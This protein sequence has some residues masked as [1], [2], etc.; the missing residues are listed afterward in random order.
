[1]DKYI[2]LVSQLPMLHFDRKPLISVEDFLVEADKWLSGRDHTV[3]IRADLLNVDP[4]PCDTQLLRRYKA[5]ERDFRND[6][7]R[8]RQTKGSDQE[9]KPRFFS[10]SALREGTPL[11]AER[12]ILR[13][14]WDFLDA[15]EHAHHFD[16]DYLVIYFLKLK[17]LHRLMIFESEK[18]L[19][20]YHSL[21]E[22][23]V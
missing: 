2:Y 14:K 7:I 3:L 12:L 5:H 19:E 9:H 16:L 13:W 15:E 1:M 20:N 11:D 17:I 22:A 18:G 4:D 10:A 6:F 21:C 8:W 23:E